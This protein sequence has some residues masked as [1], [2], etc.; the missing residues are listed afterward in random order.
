MLIRAYW[1]NCKSCG[2]DALWVEATKVEAES[3][4]FPKLSPDEIIK[5]KQLSKETGHMAEFMGH[6]DL[7]FCFLISKD[8]SF[9][10]P[11][12]VHYPISNLWNAYSPFREMPAIH[13]AHLDELRGVDLP[14]QQPNEQ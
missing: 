14:E 6:P 13:I 7:I 3:D 8:L 9:I 11:F 2:G 4:I 1:R 5:S 10:C 12:E